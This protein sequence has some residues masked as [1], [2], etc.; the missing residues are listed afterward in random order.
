MVGLVQPG[1]ETAERLLVEN[2]NRGSLIAPEDHQ[3]DRVRT[4]ID[5]ADMSTVIGCMQRG[6]VL[7]VQA[8]PASVTAS[9]GISDEPGPALPRPDR[10]GFVMK[11]RW[12][13]NP[14]GPCRQRV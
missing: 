14:P 13:E 12:T 8:R 7:H 5:H 11:Y 9:D 1:T 3:S 4:D 10:L 6:Q 2:R